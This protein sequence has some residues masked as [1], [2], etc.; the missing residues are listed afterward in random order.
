M[1]TQIACIIFAA[2]ERLAFL[3]PLLAGIAALAVYRLMRS[4]WAIKLLAGSNLSHAF[5][6]LSLP[7]K[8]L[9]VLLLGSAATLMVLAL[10]RPQW[11]KREEIVTQEGRDLFIALDIS[12][13]ML[14]T[15]CEPN[16][17]AC[18]KQKIKQLLATL[19]CE[20]VGL[21][22]FSGSAFVQCPLT[23][24]FDTFKTFL[25]HVSVETIS[26]G[27][28][29]LDQAVRTTLQTFARMEGK[30][31]KLLAI[32]TDG[33]DFSRELRHY[34]QAAQ[35]ANLRIF[36]FGVGTPEGAPIPLYN[37]DGSQAGHQKNRSGGI[38]I[39]RLNEGILQTLANDA[40][41]AYLQMTEDSRDVQT[42]VQQLQSFE[43]ETLEDKS[44]SAYEDQYHWFLLGSF[45][46]LA[47]EWVIA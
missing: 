43:K 5:R 25:D 29:A 13:S 9:Q 1:K 26:T 34:K 11:N 38:V 18:A 30:K 44:F 32:F 36:T 20:R 37:E 42:L 19:S 10:L 46:L 22:L 23:A 47:L 35:D 21:I 41:G 3:L 24:D 2:L 45:I 27:T 12:R 7:R 40:G 15:D 28:T 8:R 6:N 33:E 31:N 17:L 16:R 4:G 14:A 39:S